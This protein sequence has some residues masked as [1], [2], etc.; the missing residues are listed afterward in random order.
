[1][2]LMLRMKKGLGNISQ[3]FFIA[4]FEVILSKSETQTIPYCFTILEIE[5]LPS[6]TICNK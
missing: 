2:E 5:V 1:M 3:T 6:I 4:S